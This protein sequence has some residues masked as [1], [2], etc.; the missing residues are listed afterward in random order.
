MKVQI[1]KEIFLFCLSTMK[2]ILCLLEFKLGKNT[3]DY[4]FLKGQVMD[5]FYNGLLVLYKKLENDNIL[6]QC[7]CGARIRLGYQKCDNCSGCGYKN[8]V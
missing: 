7:P 8:K 5:A 4:K 2:A 3:D 1:A 6:E